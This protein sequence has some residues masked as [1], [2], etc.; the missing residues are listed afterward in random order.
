MHR[1]A[2]EHYCQ[3]CI[4]GERWAGRAEHLSFI[5]TRPR[6]EI[7][8]GSPAGCEPR[9]RRV[10]SLGITLSSDAESLPVGVARSF[11]RIITEL[12]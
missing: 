1:F 6:I 4:A 8:P 11:I 2:E 12:S 7:V 10:G 5:I 9:Y 3:G